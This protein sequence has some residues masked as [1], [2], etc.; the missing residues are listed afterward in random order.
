MEF[1]PQSLN[2]YA[3]SHIDSIPTL[4]RQMFE[5]VSYLHSHDIVHGDLNPGNVRVRASG[6]IALVDFGLSRVSS[7]EPNPKTISNL[8][9]RFAAP[10]WRTRLG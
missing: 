5:A 8:N 3:F 9:P 6:V 1:V 7:G 10:V 4:L 2:E